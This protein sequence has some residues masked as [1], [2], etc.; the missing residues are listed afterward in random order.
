MLFKENSQLRQ[1]SQAHSELDRREGRMRNADIA[2]CETGM[3]R[4]SQRMEL[5][6]ANQLTDQAR[7]EKSW[8]CYV[9]N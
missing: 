8:L 9:K 3:Q 4:Q 7:R 2:L 5:Y 1:L 6:Q